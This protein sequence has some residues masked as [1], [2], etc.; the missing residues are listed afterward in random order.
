MFSC[1]ASWWLYQKFWEASQL[2]LYFPA[3]I[4]LT[5]KVAGC[6]FLQLTGLPCS[7]PYQSGGL[8][9]PVWPK[10]LHQPCPEQDGLT[11]ESLG[12]SSWKTACHVDRWPAA[13]VRT[14]VSLFTAFTLVQL[15]SLL[16]SKYLTGRLH[17]LVRL[18]VSKCMYLRKT[19]HALV[20]FLSGSR[21][22][23]LALFS[24]ANQS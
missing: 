19:T 22:W 2:S 16:Q 14:V 10:Q 13:R 17:T 18:N 11:A 21:H 1:W 6:F 3:E 8:V 23:F 15:R 9:S 12:S 5:L 7:R 4:L 20:L 24:L